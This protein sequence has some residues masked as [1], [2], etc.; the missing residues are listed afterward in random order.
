MEPSF[1]AIA[2]IEFP[3]RLEF[4]VHFSSVSF[5]LILSKFGSCSRR[6]CSRHIGS[7][8][9]VDDERGAFGHAGHTEIELRQKRIV[10]DAVLARDPVFVIVSNGTLMFSF[11]PKPP[12]QTDYRR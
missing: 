6:R 11:S 8:L 7:A 4:V 10:G 2:R 5:A 12:A 3:V 1:P 9:P